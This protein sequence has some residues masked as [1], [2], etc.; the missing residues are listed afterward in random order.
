[1]GTFESMDE[2]QSARLAHRPGTVGPWSIGSLVL[3]AT[4]LI[5][6]GCFSTEPATGIGEDCVDA[7]FVAM[8]D[9]STFDPSCI[10]VE[11][12]TTVTW[13]NTSNVLHTVTAD[14]DRAVNPNNVV[15]P[16]GAAPF[17]SGN[18]STDSE[19]SYT[20]HTPGRYDY[21]CLPHEGEGMRGR[22]IVEP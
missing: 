4:A 13:E 9:V 2:A 6:S 11:S 21:V 15:L 3:G 20:F 8:T 14:P 22:I 5:I 19:F 18:L 7:D 12:G 16:D 17:H 1:M 10:R